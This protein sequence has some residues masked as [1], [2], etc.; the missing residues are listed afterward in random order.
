MSWHPARSPDR[1]WWAVSALCAAAA[2]SR[3]PFLT[4]PVSYDEGGFLTVAA[5]WHPGSS[6]YGSYW[7]DRPPLLI[8]VYAVAH[9][10]GGTVALRLI[11][12][13]A[14]VCSVALAAVV[15]R[16]GAGRRVA[17]TACAAVTAAFLVTPVFGTRIV[18]GELLA[19]PLVLGGLASLLAS[20]DAPVARARMLRVLAGGLG[21]A[22]FLVKQDMVDVLVVA[23]VLVVHEVR[24]RGPRAGLTL[25]GPV[26]AG[27]VGT[28]VAAICLSATRGTSPIGLWGAVVTFRFAADRLL[29]FSGPRLAG[30]LHAYLVSGALVLTV[31]AAL[32]CLAARRRTP[33]GSPPIGTSAAALCAWEVVAAFAGASFWSHYLIG[34]LPGIV[35]LTAAALRSPAGPGH[36]TLALVVTYAVLA[37]VVSWSIHANETVPTSDDTVTSAYLRD[38]ARPCDTVVVAFGHADI[39]HDSGLASPY[40]Y[41][42]ALPA[43]VR[44]PRLLALDRLL[45]SPAAPQWFVAGGDLSLW[46]PPGAALQR[47]VDRHYV[48]VLHTTRWTLLRRRRLT[49]GTACAAAR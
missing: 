24:H 3:L 18:D 37:A 47:V 11:G 22:A 45:V 5:Q 14:V 23:A 44:D 33:S 36:R 35:L 49:R 13:L 10:L 7:V 38:H 30:L 32:V 46:G 25:G 41:L 12:L 2:L 27:A 8:A 28:G 21:A 19:A 43:F 6:L 9:A 34:L 26:V 16:L 40:P 31:V 4:A 1:G 39:V 20:Y 15:G 48:P 42:W 17:A 29:G